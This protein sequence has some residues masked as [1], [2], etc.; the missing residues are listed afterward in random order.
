LGEARERFKNRIHAAALGVRA[1]PTDACPGGEAILSVTMHPRYVSKSDFPAPLFTALGLRAVGSRITKVKPEKWGIKEPPV[2]EVSTDEIFVAGDR[3]Q[4]LQLE[5]SVDRISSDSTAADDLSH[6]ET[7]S[8]Q[9]AQAKLKGVSAAQSWLEVVLHNQARVNVLSAFATYATELGARVDVK[10]SREVG[11]LTFVPVSASGPV[12]QQ[13]ARFSFLRVARSM[14]TL[15]PL[16]PPML[17]SA[18]KQKATLPTDDAVS[19]DCRALIFDGGIPPSVRP[20]LSRWATLI[21][22]PGIGPSHPDFEA[23]GLAVTSAFLFG[24]IENSKE[25]RRP[26][27]A[28]DHVRV[29][30]TALLSS[31]DP[32]YFDVLDRIL[33]Y[34]DSEGEKYDLVNLSVGPNTPCDDGDVTL[35]T[36]ALDQRFASGRWVVTVA[37][38]NE[39]EADA[40]LLLNRIQP[41]GDGVNVLTIGASDSIKTPWKRESYSCIGPG[42]TPGF[43]KPDGLSFGGSDGEPFRVLSPAL[44]VEGIKGTSFAS[45][46]AMRSAASIK[47]QLGDGLGGLAIRALMIHTTNKSDDLEFSEIGWGRFESDPERLIT[48]E[49]HEALVV[50]QGTLPLGEH[51]RAPIPLPDTLTGMVDISATL[52]IATEVD[53]GHPSAY[54]RSGLTISFRPHSD[55][56][57]EYDDGKTSSVPK[58]NPFFSAT[59]MYG[60]AEFDLRED[61]HKWEPCHHGSQRFRPAS[62]KNPCFD[63]YNHRRL[64]GVAT[65]AS[66]RARYA[67]VVTVSAKKVPNLYSGV[68]RAYAGILIPLRPKFRIEIK[69]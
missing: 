34:F 53:P 27:C 4:I 7:V 47:A 26:I 22:P 42:R 56:Y 14:P 33:K 58:T 30:D 57:R 9:P 60:A 23:H 50:Y 29:L 1:L 63:I 52:M 39:G 62:L 25:L 69:N 49:D 48:C 41:P 59:N 31:A 67:L 24:P 19:P 28:V 32:Y 35:W 8:F 68:L 55:K 40:F 38:G 21:V 16:R 46:F 36:S 45:P 3:D 64:E 11:G 12:S 17:R 2:G 51:L 15:R 66:E 61:G 44:E 6:I 65:E 20:S 5:R 18:A 43:A 10:R 13:I 37:A 54:T